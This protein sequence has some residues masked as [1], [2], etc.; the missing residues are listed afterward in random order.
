MREGVGGTLKQ[1]WGDARV[2]ADDSEDSAH[3]EIVRQILLEHL[4]PLV[5]A[6]TGWHAGDTKLMLIGTL[7]YGA[8]W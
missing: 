8:V 3:A 2:V 6:R 5:E 1:I 4:T 7:L